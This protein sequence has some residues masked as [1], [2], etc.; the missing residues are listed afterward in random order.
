M[1]Q[2]LDFHKQKVIKTTRVQDLDPM[3]CV[4]T[5]HES[6][7]THEMTSIEP[8]EIPSWTLTWKP[9]T[10]L[11]HIKCCSNDDRFSVSQWESFFYSNLGV[12][13]PAL[14]GPAQWC[15]CNSL[16]YDNFGDHLQTCQTKSA[17]SQVHDWVVYNMGTLL[18]SLGHKVKIHKITPTTDK[19]RGDIEI[20]DYV[21]M[22]KPQK[23]L[24]VN[25]PNRF[26][27][28]DSG[29]YRTLV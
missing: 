13:T 6:V 24:W 28:F 15:T 9:L 19:E 21:V 5:T 8:S 4:D 26:H 10:F 2:Q 16:S 25:L 27:S 12:T 18:D 17:S 7:L 3:T 14:L 22:Q 11:S 23:T 20:K 29:H 1:L